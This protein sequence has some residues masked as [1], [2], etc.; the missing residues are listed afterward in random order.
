ME[1]T[2]TRTVQCDSVAIT[3]V[4]GTK[5][6][7]LRKDLYNAAHHMSQDSGCTNPVE[8]PG[9]F[10]ELY[11][12]RKVERL[13]RQAEKWKQ[14]YHYLYKHYVNKNAKCTRLEAALKN[15]GSTDQKLQKRFKK[16]KAKVEQLDRRLREAK[17]KL[18]QREHSN[19]FLRDQLQHISHGQVKGKCV[20]Q[21]IKD[22]KSANLKLEQENKAL[23]S[24]RAGTRTELSLRKDNKLLHLENLRLQK[25]LNEA[26]ASHD[27]AREANKNLYQVILKKTHDQFIE[28]EYQEQVQ[29]ANRLSK[30]N[31]KIRHTLNEL[32]EENEQLT[33]KLGALQSTSI[34]TEIYHRDCECLHTKLK[35]AQKKLHL[36][37]IENQQLHENLERT[38]KQCTALEG[39][40]RSSKHYETKLVE[41]KSQ[42]KI[43]QEVRDGLLKELNDIKGTF[44]H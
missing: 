5:S 14:E 39:A 20:L 44:A 31:K 34:S 9:M 1:T 4:K 43:L 33:A 13:E 42:I 2:Q 26:I 15:Y 18:Q 30:E 29:I 35:A 41:A 16:A 28:K 6:E 25:K 12:P 19:Q 32:S 8:G 11:G 7:Q 23:K 22:L 3:Y 38:A 10:N 24:A 36:L 40:Y 27:R 17:T 37:I 21:E